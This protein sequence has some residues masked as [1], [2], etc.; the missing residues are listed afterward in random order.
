MTGA[1][2]RGRAARLSSRSSWRSRRG[3]GW[4]RRR[5]LPCPYREQD[6]GPEPQ[7]RDRQGRGGR[8]QARGSSL[9][10]YLQPRDPEWRGLRPWRTSPGPV[11]VKPDG[12]WSASLKVVAKFGTVD[13]FKTACAIQTSRVGQ[14]A[15]RT[16]EAYAAISFTGQT[17]PAWVPSA[18][19]AASE[20]ATAPASPSATPRRHRCCA[21][22]TGRDRRGIDDHER[23]RHQSRPS[24]SC[25]WWSSPWSA[26]A[27]RTP[28]ATQ[29]TARP[30]R[31]AHSS[32]P[33]TPRR[34]PATARRSVRSFVDS[35]GGRPYGSARE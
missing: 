26:A 31:R 2:G 30:D 3:P 12:T 8:L 35:G 7:G 4:L 21:R 15:D 18:T 1:T 14:G 16:Q 9:P 19:P 28:D 10:G 25:C 11:D 34:A 23:Q 24:G 13:C 17:V 22:H 20:T 29:R 5:S 27:W 32:R 33:S 6:R